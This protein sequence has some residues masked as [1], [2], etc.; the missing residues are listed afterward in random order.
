[1]QAVA[2]VRNRGWSIVEAYTPYPVHG[3]D[4]AMDLPRSRLSAA[5][6]FCG[7]VGVS[8]ALFFQFW[9][10]GWDWPMNVAGQPWNSLPAFVP[11][12]FEAMVLFAGVGLIL[13]WLLRSRLYPGKRPTLVLPAQTDDRFVLVFGPGAHDLNADEVRE[14]L[15]QAS[16][17]L[18]EQEA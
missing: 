11:V 18:L 8:S 16:G 10:T 13:A 12:T 6:F 9:S 15:A 3:L 7:V 5:C 14:V 4:T 17:R 1:L 2:A